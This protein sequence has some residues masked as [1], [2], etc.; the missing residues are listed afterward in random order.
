MLQPEKVNN[1]NG[2]RKILNEPIHMASMT[3]TTNETEDVKSIWMP[4]RDDT[5]VSC[6]YYL[7]LD[8]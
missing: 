5:L 3:I 4:T 8:C 1:S 6:Y 7:S 2:P